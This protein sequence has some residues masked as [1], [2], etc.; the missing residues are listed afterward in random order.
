MVRRA[1]TS[2][3]RIGAMQGARVHPDALSAWCK[4]G[5]GG[6]EKRVG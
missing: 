1:N 3:I 5:A 6:T 4:G 2:P